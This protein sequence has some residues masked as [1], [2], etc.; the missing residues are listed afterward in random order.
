M[1]ENPKKFLITEDTKK[2]L[3]IITLKRTPNSNITEK[4]KEERITED[5]QELQD[6]Q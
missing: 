1:T 3:S 6:L 2:T 4:P 5:L